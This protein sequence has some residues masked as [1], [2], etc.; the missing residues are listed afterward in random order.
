MVDLTNIRALTFDVFGTVVDWR[1]GVAREAE[2]MLAPKG[3]AL[4]WGA[5]ADAWRGQYQPAMAEVRSGA[6]GYVVMDVLH[7]E[8]L[9][10]ALAQFGVAELDETEKHRLT[11][12]WRRLDPWPDVVEGI[13]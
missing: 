13:G 8:M 4:D 6:R 9:E 7:R 10:V 1:A 5:F 3:H 11:M 12:G 2:A